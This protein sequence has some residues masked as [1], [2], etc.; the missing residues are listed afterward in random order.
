MGAIVGGGTKEGKAM[1]AKF[2]TS[3]PAFGTLSEK[4][5]K[6]AER[7]FILALDGRRLP[8]RSGHGAINSLLQGAAAVIAKQWVVTTERNC[9]KAGLV[10]GKD[11]WISAF[12]HDEQQITVKEE[13]AELV[14]KISV[15]S[16]LE[17]GEYLGV[18][19]PVGAE[20]KIGFNWY[21]TH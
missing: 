11:F 13:H 2:F 6:A 7:G 21:D 9:E 14:S 4:V 17:A 19:I 20:S 8:V 12:V 3:L 15:D 18:R 1:K 10:N 5:K 16:A